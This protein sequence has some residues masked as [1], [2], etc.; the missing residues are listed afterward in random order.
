MKIKP[1]RLWS[2]QE[3]FWAGEFGDEYIARNSSEQLLASNLH[4][5]SKALGS[6]TKPT[7]CLEFGA[8]IGMNLKAL[9]LLFPNMEMSGIEINSQ[10]AGVLS[11]ALGA[12][13]VYEGSL[14][15]FQSQKSWDLCIVK[16]VLIHMAPEDLVEAYG[17]IHEACGRYLLI[18][19]YYS[20][21][22]ISVEYR[23]HADRLFKRDF[24]GEF[25][26]LF[27]AFRLV[28]YG[29]GYRGDVAFP[30]DDLNWFLLERV[31][32]WPQSADAR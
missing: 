25:L 31:E 1:K 13:N 10:A 27:P 26:G 4:F 12:S 23:G 6:M 28:N 14:L 22:P 24:A 18:S 16:G 9:G 11:Q 29:F 19:E 3:Q 8:N 20:P 32:T 15:D 7:S 17:I 2:A 30:E 5:F 21:Y